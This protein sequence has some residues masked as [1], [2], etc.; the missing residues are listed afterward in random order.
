MANSISVSQSGEQPYVPLLYSEN[1]N[2]YM[3]LCR[4]LISYYLCLLERTEYM[5]KKLRKC[6]CFKDH[7]DDLIKSNLNSCRILIGFLMGYMKM[8]Q[9]DTTYLQLQFI[10]FHGLYGSLHRAERMLQEV[11]ATNQKITKS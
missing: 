11:Q 3:V 2:S 4:R 6:S 5:I 8:M 1:Q 9:V 10:K 7:H